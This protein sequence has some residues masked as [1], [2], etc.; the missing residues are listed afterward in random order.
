M[1]RRATPATDIGF[2]SFSMFRSLLFV[3]YF[4]QSVTIYRPTPRNDRAS[5]AFRPKKA[6]DF[7][8]ILEKARIGKRRLANPA[9]RFRE[10]ARRTLERPPGHFCDIKC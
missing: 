9:C 6:A 1:K 5:G 8:L 4:S 10:A 7:S 2:D 3:L